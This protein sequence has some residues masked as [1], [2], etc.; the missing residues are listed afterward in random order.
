MKLADNLEDFAKHEHQTGV[1]PSD[2][3]SSW[4]EKW[5]CPTCCNNVLET[6]H[7]IGCTNITVKDQDVKLS[8]PKDIIGSDKLPMGLVPGTTKAYLALGHMEGMLKYGLVNWRE[9][10]VRFSIYKDALERHMEK[11]STYGEWEDPQTT[12]PHLANAIACL[13]IIIDA[14]ETGKL[15][16]DRPKSVKTDGPNVIDRFSAK[17]KH[18]RKM[19]ADYKPKHWTIEDK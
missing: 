19:F 15:I 9:A 4:T 11:L 17:V 6:N 12:V 18:L 1:L 2:S 8:N 5:I 7:K 10:G 16:D 3:N 14:Y 13:S